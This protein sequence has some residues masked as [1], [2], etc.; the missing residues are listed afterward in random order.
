[1]KPIASFDET[2]YPPITLLNCDMEYMGFDYTHY[3]PI[4]LLNYYE[5]SKGEPDLD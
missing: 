5:K 1:M 4:T 2:Y 3:Q